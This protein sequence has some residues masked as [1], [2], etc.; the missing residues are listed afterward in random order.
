MLLA[1]TTCSFA[2]FYGTLFAFVIT[3]K[4]RLAV[5]ITKNLA[6]LFAATLLAAPANAALFTWRANGVITNVND[7]KGWLTHPAVGGLTVVPVAGVTPWSVEI[8]VNSQAPDV[9]SP[10]LA[11]YEPG[12]VSFTILVGGEILGMPFPD[13]IPGSI[14]LSRVLVADDPS[15]DRLHFTTTERG[16]SVVA[17]GDFQSAWGLHYLDSSGTPPEMMNT[18]D[19]PCTPPESWDYLSFTAQYDDIDTSDHSSIGGSV[20]SVAVEGQCRVGTGIPIEYSDEFDDRAIA[21][22]GDHDVNDPG[23]VLM[24]HLPIVPLQPR[25]ATD[26]FPADESGTPVLLQ[27]DALAHDYDAFVGELPSQLTDL[28]VSLDLDEGVD[29]VAAYYQRPNG[30][31]DV[32]LRHSDLNQDIGPQGGPDVDDVDA[33]NL[34]G[35]E[36]VA[37]STFFS[38]ENDFDNVHSVFHFDLGVPVGFVSQATIVSIVETLG[39]VGDTTAVDVD[40]LM[41][42]NTG[43]IQFFDTGDAMIFSIRAA[44]NFDGG[45]I[46][47]WENGKSPVF[48]VHAGVKFDTAHDVSASFGLANNVQEIDALEAGPVFD[49]LNPP[50]PVPVSVWAAGLIASLLGLVGIGAVKRRGGGIRSRVH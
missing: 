5:S 16:S 37:D 29:G 13:D 11:I 38:A 30:D 24:S 6:L 34:W 14:D 22:G 47:T 8:V 20:A 43:D 32:A 12:I 40:A 21:G 19:F 45:E 41:F 39:Y 7:T 1:E 31:R 9:G 25:D 36:G 17:S 27:V 46:I 15:Q 28:V 26:F 10:T 49:V 44:G 50:P 48:L 33:L 4:W 18:F 35:A 3:R 2:P 23:Q 42:K